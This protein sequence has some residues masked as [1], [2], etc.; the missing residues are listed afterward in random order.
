MTK[1]FGFFFTKSSNQHN[2]QYKSRSMNE[3]FILTPTCY[4]SIDLCHFNCKTLINLKE[5]E[6]NAEKHITRK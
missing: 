4:H 6:A 2:I 3:L 5:A 1:H